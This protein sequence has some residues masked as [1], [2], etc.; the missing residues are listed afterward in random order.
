MPHVSGCDIQGHVTGSLPL[1]LAHYVLTDKEMEYC[2]KSVN[3]TN[4]M[5]EDFIL[6]VKNT[7]IAQ[8]WRPP[9]KYDINAVNSQHSLHMMSTDELKQTVTLSAP[10]DTES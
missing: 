9:N 8:P 10:L 4:V 2:C 5:T 1:K 3:F 6:E 7:Q